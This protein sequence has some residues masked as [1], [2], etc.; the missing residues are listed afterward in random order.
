MS[1]VVPVCNEEV[2]L[3]RKAENLV[4]YL[5]R[6]RVPFEI[7]FVENGSSDKTLDILQSLSNSHRCIRIQ[8]LPRP[9]YSASILHGISSARGDFVITMGIDFSDLAVIDRCLEALKEAD[10]VICS[11]NLGTD[12][13]P[14]MRRVANR[15]YNALVRVVFGINYSDVEG[16]HGFR[17]RSVQEMVESIDT[18]AHLFN[19]WL[20]LYARRLSLNI[21]EVPVYVREERPSRSFQGRLIVYLAFVTLWEFVKLKKKGL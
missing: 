10:I 6:G 12:E 18:R 17:K 4:E 19:L 1:V 21:K 7:V 14:L 20:L 8:K 11:K 16:Y 15:G 5:A 13:R 9:D 2:I 3:K